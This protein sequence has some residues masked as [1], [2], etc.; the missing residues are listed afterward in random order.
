LGGFGAG[1]GVPMP[2]TRDAPGRARGGATD[3][4]GS[5]LGLAIVQTVVDNLG[6]SVVLSGRADGGHGLVARIVLPL[7]GPAAEALVPA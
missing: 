5:G 2:G 3:E 6:G 7:V 4:E 1:M